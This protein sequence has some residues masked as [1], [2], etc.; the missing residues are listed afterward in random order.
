[1]NKLLIATVALVIVFSMPALAVTVFAM[2]APGALASP[3]RFRAIPDVSKNTE[4]NPEHRQFQSTEQQ[5]QN[6]DA[7]GQFNDPHWY[8]NGNASE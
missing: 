4:A 5:S 2:P 6:R 8:S 3:P 7:A 1:M